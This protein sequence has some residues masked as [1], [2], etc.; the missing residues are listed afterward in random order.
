MLSGAVSIASPS[1]SEQVVAEYLVQA[2]RQCCDDAYVDAVG[3]AIGRWGTGRLRVW[4]LGHIDTVPGHIDVRLVDGELYGRGAVDAKGSFCAFVAAVAELPPALAE[5]LSITLIGAVGEEAPDSV[6]AR[7]AVMSLP[8]PDLVVIGEPSGWDALTLGYKGTMQVELVAVEPSRHTSVDEPTAAEKVVEAY[9]AIRHFVDELNRRAAP[10]DGGPADVDPAD[11]D[12]A[13]NEHL[14]AAVPLFESLQLRLL[15][16]SAA[17][18]GLTQRARAR[19]GFRLPPQV[20]ATA[21]AARL[22]TLALAEGAHCEVV[23]GAVEAYRSPKNG[24]LASAFRVAIR[25]AGGTPRHKLKM[26]TADMNVVAAAWHSGGFEVPPMLAYGPGD[27]NLDH[28][29]Q[30]RLALA[31]YRSAIN[32]LREALVALGA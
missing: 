25:A 31:E 17:D 19:L 24:P 21:V 16:V 29:P 15:S 8:L 5:K 9:N 3:N 27:A 2:M 10:A 4:L 1:G 30:E 20:S 6:G 26:G 22:S 14:R 32:V 11:V 23:P 28:T 12:P 18:D 7:H 13:R